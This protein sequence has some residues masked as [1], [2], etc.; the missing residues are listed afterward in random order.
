MTKVPTSSLSGRRKSGQP[1]RPLRLDEPPA[2]YERGVLVSGGSSITTQSRIHNKLNEVTKYATTPVLYDHG[3]N[4][5]PHAGRGNGNIADDGIRTYAYDAFNRL[6]T[7]SDKSSGLTIG[8][9]TYDAMG[10]RIVKIVSNGGLSGTITNGTTRYLYAQNQCVEELNASG[11]TTRQFIWGQYIDELVQL[12]TYV[13]TGSQPLPTGFY[14][15]L[16][17]LLYRS[18]AL[19]DSGGSIVEA[20]DTDAYG[21]TIIFAAAGTG[22]NWWANNAEQALQ[23]ACEY[24]FTGRQYDPESEIYFYRARYYH[25]QLGRF[26]SRDPL[27][28]SS[29]DYQRVILWA[30]R[31]D[32]LNL[33]NLVNDNPTIKIDPLGLSWYSGWGQAVLAVLGQADPAVQN[34]F[35]TSNWDRTNGMLDAANMDLSKLGVRPRGN[36]GRSWT[37]DPSNRASAE[38]FAKCD[39]KK[40]FDAATMA[41]LSS[42]GGGLGLLGTAPISPSDIGSDVLGKQSNNPIDL[43]NPINDTGLALG[44]GGRALKY[45][46]SGGTS[47]LGLRQAWYGAGKPGNFMEWAGARAN[48]NANLTQLGEAADKLGNAMAVAGLLADLAKCYQD[49]R[50]CPDSQ[51]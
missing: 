44:Y 19:A 12:R 48:S 46:G 23:P 42:L 27:Y 33:Y 47:F 3:N 20:Y 4:T 10:R 5:T 1:V 38:C 36:D 22:G 28:R 8:Q 6:T 21:N 43:T 9:Y 29:C 24:I 51:H 14:Y 50:K 18:I 41:K 15:L 7:V 32:G 30:H 40:T 17:D 31:F 26:I 35:D 39:A 16:S 11:S 49:C 2:N 45:L 37:F 25:P 13:A 34:A